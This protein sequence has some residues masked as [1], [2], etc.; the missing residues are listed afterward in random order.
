MSDNGLN[1]E[2]RIVP[3]SIMHSR[4]SWPILLLAT[5]FVIG[6]FLTWYFTWFGR[7]L[8][9]ADV[10]AY[11][12]DEKHPR[13]VQHALLQIQ[14]RME[15]HDAGA[16][17]WYPQLIALAGNPETELR[18]TVAWVMGFDNKDEEFHHT[19]LKLLQDS[20]PIVRRNAALAL[21]KFGDLSGRQE[22]RNVLEPYPVK[23]TAG[24]VVSSALK[25][26]SSI[27]RGTL[28][29]RLQDGSKL[30]EVRSP[31][32][33]TIESVATESGVTVTPDTL[34]LTLASD[35]ESIWEALRGLA[36]IG[37]REDREAIE[38][39][40][41]RGT[42]ND[43]LKEQAALTVKAIQGRENLR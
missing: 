34:L 43:R 36:L 24:G 41:Q 22:I 20:E 29:A 7:E 32:P 8:S 33:G 19:L 5:L 38:R 1:S 3:A 14:Q 12:V 25:V 10:S 28:L 30:T 2:V 31:L 16:K 37:E 9:D 13:K 27:S 26:G 11:L 40:L 4:G 21:I 18:L 23:A 42:N 6:A 39:Y 35:E 17:H 15:R